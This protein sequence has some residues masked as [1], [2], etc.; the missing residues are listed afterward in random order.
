[1]HCREPLSDDFIL[2][3]TSLGWRTSKYKL[4]KEQLLYE[5]ERAQLPHTQH[6]AEAY[7]NAK[8]IM[9]PVAIE[10]TSCQQI[11]SLNKSLVRNIDYYRNFQEGVVQ[12]DKLYIEG[13]LE[14]HIPNLKTLTIKELTDLRRG[15]SQKRSETKLR[16]F[17][18]HTT[19]R[20]YLPIVQSYGRDIGQAEKTRV[21]RTIVKACPASG[22]SAF[23]NEEFV[24]GLCKTEVCKKCHEIL[25]AD[26]VCNEDTV[27]SIKALHAEARPCP[28]CATLIS[29]IDGCDQMWCTQCK[30]TFSWRTGLVETGVTHNPHYYEWMRRNGGLPRAPGDAPG[31]CN[32]FPLTSD[33][34]NAKQAVKLQL[35]NSR[36]NALALKDTLLDD[37]EYLSYLRLSKYHQELQHIHA[38]N[39]TPIRRPDNFVLRVKLLTKEIPE[40]AFK[41]T[42][43][44]DDKAY[45]KRVAKKHVYDMAYAAAGD[46]LRN[47]IAQTSF[48]DTLTQIESLLQYSNTAL[49]RIEKAYSCKADKYKLMPFTEEMK[50]H[51][52][53]FSI[54]HRYY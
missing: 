20:I 54:I 31:G 44:R 6:N 48:A 37:P 34:M 39:N 36:Q 16:L 42:L 40:C 24:C 4:Y 2:D 3:N 13:F 49:E 1:M 10:I 26:H 29:K 8:A 32:E 19:E 28:A 33:L 45:R 9:G 50:L 5:I 11:Y 52:Y 25:V 12:P 53:W 23:L 30:T 27:A 46:I 22:C 35:I 38:H 51:S 41:V 15:F 14:K 43:Q 18:L 21:K 17:H 47:C 7:T